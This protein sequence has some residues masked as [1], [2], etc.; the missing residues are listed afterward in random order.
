MFVIAESN[1]SQPRGHPGTHYPPNPNGG[2]IPFLRS[3]GIKA[4]DTISKELYKLF[5]KCVVVPLMAWAWSFVLS[6]IAD[7]GRLRNSCVSFLRM[8]LPAP[9][10][11]PTTLERYFFYLATFLVVLKF[12]KWSTARKVKVD[13]DPLDIIQDMRDEVMKHQD[14][15]LKG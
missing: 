6:Q 14:E 8:I 10:S 7:F 5:W 12:W 11:Q 1:R 15:T 2:L 13:D 4:W 3:H 9:N